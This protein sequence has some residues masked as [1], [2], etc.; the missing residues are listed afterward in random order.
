MNL[1]PQWF[2]LPAIKVV[3]NL[4]KEM[5]S[6][7]RP[8]SKPLGLISSPG[9]IFLAA[10]SSLELGPGLFL[11][12]CIEIEVKTA[13]LLFLDLL[14]LLLQLVLE[15]LDQLRTVEVFPGLPCVLLRAEAFPGEVVLHLQNKK[16]FDQK[17]KLMLSR[18]T[19]P[20]RTLL[21][22][23][24]STTNSSPSSAMIRESWNW[25]NIKKEVNL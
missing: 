9:W 3:N 20:L 10:G 19:F 16:S 2:V 22:R 18:L 15:S 23:I 12:S 7:W 4:A 8:L 25:Q 1:L 24:L 6:T 13:F 21:S 14:L 17:R 5:K 11:F